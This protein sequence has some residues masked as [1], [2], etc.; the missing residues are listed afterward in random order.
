MRRLPLIALVTLSGCWPYIPGRYA[1]YV[2]DTS[3]EGDTDT[4]TDTDVEPS[5]VQLIGEVR[6]DLYV[7]DYWDL[8]GADPY[9]GLAWWGLL[10]TPQSAYSRIAA[11]HATGT[12]CVKNPDYSGVIATLAAG[13]AGSSTIVTA[14][15]HT[16]SLPW[17]SSY[18]M[19][20]GM[21]RAFSGNV[22]L[23]I[24]STSHSSDTWAVSKWTVVPS[25]VLFSGPTLDGTQPEYSEVA[26]LSWTWS[27]A[28]P[29]GVDYVRLT[30]TQADS[31][32]TVVETVSCLVDVSTK[33]VAIPAAQWSDPGSASYWL[34]EL[35]VISETQS[36][37]TGHTGVESLGWGVHN[38]VG[39]LFNL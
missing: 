4:D 8:G 38:T 31:S 24:R 27:S 18:R 39:A 5:G 7:G 9:T 22:E 19:Y 25:P 11:Y 35:A 33:R 20:M 37:I 14:G 28:S 36:T 2:E 15:G 21:T 1:D 3:V 29:H 13:G 16:E 26:D 12:G 17:E 23:G 10:S 30:A 34:I 32:G 6:H